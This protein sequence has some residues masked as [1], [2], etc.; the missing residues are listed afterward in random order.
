MSPP[1]EDAFSGLVAGLRDGDEEAAAAFYGRYGPLLERLADKNLESGIR[2]RVG[3]DEVAHSACRTFLRRIRI[4]EFSLDGRDDLWNLLCAITVA[5]VR[6]KVRFHRAQKRGVGREIRGTTDDDAPSPDA[7]LPTEAL[8][9]ADAAEIADAVQHLLDGLNDE[10]RQ[11]VCL[12]LEQRTDEGVADAI[13][14]SERTVR[15]LR[16]RIQ[17]RWR[18]LIPDA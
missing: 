2:R 7:V 13:G 12:K 8:G 14:C 15:R 10:E 11:L 17:E 1:A 4:G 6:K 18:S 9:P 16:Q 3:G 5:K